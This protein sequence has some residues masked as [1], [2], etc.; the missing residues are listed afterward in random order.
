MIVM[1]KVKDRAPSA[2]ILGISLLLA[3]IT[4]SS[5]GVVFDSLTA[6][7][8]P[9]FLA[10]SWRLWCQLSILSIPFYYT[11]K[12]IRE[13]DDRALALWADNHELKLG[14]STGHDEASSI[15]RDHQQ[16][17]LQDDVGT[18]KSELKLPRY[19]ST[20]PL[21]L[22]S[23]FFLGVHF[24]SWVYSIQKTSLV[25]SLLWVSMGP[26]I[27]NWGHWILYNFNFT[28]H[29][30]SILESIGAILG[31]IG[32]LI[33]LGDVRA[34]YQELNDASIDNDDL[35][36]I[37]QPTLEGDMAALIGAFAVSIYLIIGQHC[38]SWMPL[39]LYAFPVIA[40]AAFTSMVAALLDITQPSTLFGFEVNAVLGFL[41]TKYFLRA[42]Y[43]GVGP[44]ICG[45]T[46]FNALL[47]YVS[48]LTISTAM[49][50][51]PIFGSIIG[52]FLGMQQLPGECTVY[53]G[54]ILMVGLVFVVLGE[55][56]NTRANDNDVLHD[57]C[58]DVD[59]EEKRHLIPK[60]NAI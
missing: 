9:P 43:L 55:N 10:A 31:L 28:N 15:T 24:S 2:I 48:P 38:R 11:L 27:I 34:N 51:E 57:V 23:G 5:A 52:Y 7:G 60:N 1:V 49:L 33:M 56:G 8:V 54:A 20:L 46:M 18:K 32:A 50:L 3:V 30:P 53:G 19:L 26:I 44:G 29:V 6:E 14:E 37:H 39:W 36:L 16:L 59:S 47:K 21:L 41:N 4:C 35:D 45:H 40:A 42:V 12:S 22:C 17:N 58:N 25:H 13:D